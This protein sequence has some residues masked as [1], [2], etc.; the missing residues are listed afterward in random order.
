VLEDKG[1][2]VERKLNLGGTAVTQASIERGEIDL[3]PEY[4]GTALLAVLKLPSSSNRQKVYETVSK[5]YK[6]KF[7]LIWL[8]PA[9]MSNTFALCMIK[10]EAKKYGIKTISDLVAKASE[11]SMI[12]AP[13]FQER[14]DGLPGLKKVYGNFKL[15]KYL[16][17]DPGLR[18]Q[19]LIS[20]QA[21]VV[22]G[23]ATDGE[24]NA[25][26]LVIIQDNKNFFPPYQVAPVVRRD[27]IEKNAGLEGTLNNLSFKI[28]DETMRRLNYQ[29]TGEKREPSEVAKMFLKQEG[30]LK[31]T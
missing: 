3:Y 12:G 22:V 26:N 8:N 15:K 16:P 11:L 14:E 23:A 19:G 1:F 27:V 10:A 6:E 21:D 28:T 13:E 4:T 5:E 31:S 17:V 7:N 18:Y 29:V 20:G 30:L 25:L 24:I 9:P 2:K